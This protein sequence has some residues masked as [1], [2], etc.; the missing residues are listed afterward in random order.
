[1]KDKTLAAFSNQLMN[2]TC[3]ATR[4]PGRYQDTRIHVT[5]TGRLTDP[6]GA[7]YW[8]GSFDEVRDFPIPDDR[9]RRA[10]AAI[11]NLERIASRQSKSASRGRR[12]H[13][14]DHAP[15]RLDPDA[16]AREAVAALQSRA[17]FSK[18]RH[19]WWQG[20]WEYV[21]KFPV[22]TKVRDLDARTVKVFLKQI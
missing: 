12:S 6:L 4:T 13:A 2:D 22:S 21:R 17:S 19:A 11:Q 18:T 20:L 7:D 8:S 3:R 14:M 15:I 5:E 1:M 9:S 16:P 10:S